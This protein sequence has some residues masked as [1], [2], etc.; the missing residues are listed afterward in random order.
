[1]VDEARSLIRERGGALFNIGRFVGKTRRHR[2][3]RF[4]IVDGGRFVRKQRRYVVFFYVRR[5]EIIASIYDG[6]NIYT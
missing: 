4:W 5:M 6:I 2:R 3:G 1:M